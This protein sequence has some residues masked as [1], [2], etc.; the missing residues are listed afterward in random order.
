MSMTIY[1]F[2]NGNFWH[3]F[4][5]W[6]PEIFVLFVLLPAVFRIRIG[7]NADPNPDPVFHVNPDPDPDPGFW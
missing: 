3:R 4:S 5:A 2:L 7:F 1:I 6:P